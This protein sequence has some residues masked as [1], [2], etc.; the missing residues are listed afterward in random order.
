MSKWPEHEKL[1]REGCVSEEIS[2]FIVWLWAS[3]TSAPDGRSNQ[4][5][6]RDYLGVDHIALEREQLAIKIA[7]GPDLWEKHL[8]E[9][10]AKKAVR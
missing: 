7:A 8:I 1:S 2:D 9:A 10:A 3:G 6:V 4:Q 5:L